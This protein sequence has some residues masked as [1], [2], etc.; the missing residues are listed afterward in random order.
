LSFLDELKQYPHWIVRGPDKVPWRADGAGKASPTDP[1]DWSDYATAAAVCAAH[2]EANLGLGFVLADSDPF[3]CIDLDPTEDPSILKSQVEI[4]NAFNSYTEYSPSGKGCHIWVRGNVPARRLASKKLEVYSNQRYMT[5]TF[6]PIRD[7]PI[8]DAQNLLQ[9]LIFSI[10]AASPKS[11]ID[12]ASQPQVNS[13]EQIYKLAAQATNG[14]KFV[15]LWNADFIADYDSQSEADMA[16]CNILAF[17]SDNKKQVARMFMAS[18]LGDGRDKYKKRPNLLAKMVDK[19]FDQKMPSIEPAMAMLETAKLKQ[20]QEQRKSE[21]TQAAYKEWTYPPGSVGM[22]AEFI[23]SQAPSPLKE[24]ALAGAIAYFSG[25]MGRAYHIDGMGLN[26]YI[27]VLAK[28]GQGKDAAKVGIGKLQAMLHNHLQPNVDISKRMGPES[29]ASAQG[30]LKKVHDCPCMLSIFP[31][32]GLMLQNICNP[33]AYSNEVNI[34]LALLKLYSASGPNNVIGG[35][36]YSDKSKN[37]EPTRSPSFTLLGE[38]TP[39]QF[40]RAV[41]ED[42]VANGFLPRL[43]IIEYEGDSPEPNENAYFVQPSAEMQLLLQSQIRFAVDAE[44]RFEFMAV[45]MNAEAKVFFKQLRKQCRKMTDEHNRNNEDHLAEIWTRFAAKVAKLAATIAVGVDVTNPTIT[46]PV[47]QWAHDYIERGNNKLIS[48]FR[49]GEV[50]NSNYQH[51]QTRLVEKQ[52]QK[53]LA[54]IWCPQFER[55]YYVNE[56]QKS[57]GIVHFQ[58]LNTNLRNHKAFK[59]SPNMK[60]AFD[61]TIKLLLDAGKL[62]LVEKNDAMRGNRSGSMFRIVGEV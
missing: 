38:S 35:D 6:Q 48:R 14:D 26:Q 41:D 58:Y 54:A 47:M 1:A 8:I 42:S 39:G 56:F 33:K 10:D 19:S 51:E 49:A 16:L 53:Y 40:Y 46:M 18:K 2:P 25:L 13:D 29:I 9:D 36:A 50:G 30:L 23:Y 52:L 5:V 4:F 34:R 43:T 11:Q 22:I 37:L 60:M 21:E 17:Y 27:V 57:A 44:N 62:A 15:K 20:Q 12:V 55:S 3:A 31:E 24:V 7:I 32:F 59:N 45:H 61:N 28:T